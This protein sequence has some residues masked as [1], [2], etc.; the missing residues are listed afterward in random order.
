MSYYAFEDMEEK[1]VESIEVYDCI[2]IDKGGNITL[3]GEEVYCCFC[4]HMVVD[5]SFKCDIDTPPCHVSKY[6]A[7]N[8]CGFFERG[9]RETDCTHSGEA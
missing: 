7:E 1:P 6:N 4:K 3:K 5:G 8:R 9:E 2:L